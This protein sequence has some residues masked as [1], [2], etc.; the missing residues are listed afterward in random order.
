M[1]EL[2]EVSKPS[3]TYAVAKHAAASGPVSLLDMLKRYAFS[4]YEVISRIEGLRHRAELL[5]SDKLYEHELK[6][7]IDTLAEMLTE[8]EKLDLIST[9][10]LITHIQSEV[11]RKGKKYSHHALSNHLDTFS[12]TFADELRRNTFFRIAPEK[13]KYFEVS[14]LFGPDVS[15]AFGACGDEIKSAGTCY[16]LE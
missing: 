13:D 15:K 6:A 3:F 8:C 1:L 4:F 9:T 5:G 16:A 11:N 10:G 12:F 14:D 7:L 2:S